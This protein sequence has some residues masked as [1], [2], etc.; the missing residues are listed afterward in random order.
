LAHHPTHT[1]SNTN[2][3]SPISRYNRTSAA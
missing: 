1:D 2:P 3:R